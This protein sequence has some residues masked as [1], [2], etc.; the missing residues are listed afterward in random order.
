MQRADT[1]ELKLKT[2]FSF[3]ELIAMS[4]GKSVEKKDPPKKKGF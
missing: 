4:V 3:D 2:G 1:N